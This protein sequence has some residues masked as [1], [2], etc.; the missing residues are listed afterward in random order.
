[1]KRFAL[2]GNPV[3]HSRSPELFRAAYPHDDST[4]CLA[5]SGTFDEAFSAFMKSFDAVNVTAPYKEQAFN[6]ADVADN[7]SRMARASN[8]LVRKGNQICAYN[9]DVFAVREILRRNCVKENAAVLVVGCGGAGRAAAVAASGMNMDVT[10]ADRTYARAA[11]FCG[12]VGGMR[13]FRLEDVTECA[14]KAD[15]VIYAL[16]V[17]VDCLDTMSLR[18]KLVIEA[19]YRT[20][21]L[22]ELCAAVGASYV[23]GEE[24]LLLQAV[25]GF[26][27]M[28]GNTPDEQSMRALLKLY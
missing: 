20:P 5:P 4:Y 24:W 9:S 11:E 28:T 25:T 12:G 18:G 8:V 3:S 6:A 2:I 10:V 16:P 17:P 26:A 13:P 15:V 14:G 27:M 23:P 1:M 21:S 7:D 19:N 22:K